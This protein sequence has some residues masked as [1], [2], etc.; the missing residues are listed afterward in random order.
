MIVLAVIHVASIAFVPGFTP[1]REGCYWTS[2]LVPYIECPKVYAGRVIA[3]VLNMPS[4][5]FYYMP[6]FAFYV[7]GSEEGRN[8]PI[9]ARLGF[10]SMGVLCTGFMVVGGAYPIRW[11]Y[12]K[13]RSK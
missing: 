6:A 2:A 9:I 10:L 4:W 8:A 7:I 3:F 5:V 11:I 12:L 1:A 13:L